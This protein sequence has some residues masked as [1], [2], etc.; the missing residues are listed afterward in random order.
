MYISYDA[1]MCRALDTWIIDSR[2]RSEPNQSLLLW[3]KCGSV[4]L[5][6]LPPRE[7]HTKILICAQSW[8]ALDL[9]N[10][11]DRQAKHS[12]AP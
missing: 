12:A 9:H 10:A 5:L 2:A 6:L 7:T 3:Y 4:V 11:N 1:F 8:L